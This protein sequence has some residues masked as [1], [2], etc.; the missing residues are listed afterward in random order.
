MQQPP[1]PNLNQA[2]I[3]G[4]YQQPS[5]DGLQRPLNP[6]TNGIPPTSY[7]RPTMPQQQYQQAAPF[8]PGTRPGFNPQ[9]PGFV[10]PATVGGARPLPQQPMQPM[11]PR[12]MPAMSGGISPNLVG[13]GTQQPMSQQH[14]MAGMPQLQMPLQ[15]QP[16]QQPMQQ[17][18]QMQQPIQQQPQQPVQQPIQQQPMQ[19]NQ[20]M[21]TAN[22]PSSRRA[23]PEQMA[24]YGGPAS[25]AIDPFN[26][27]NVPIS[28]AGY[29][30]VDQGMSNNGP[31]YNRNPSMAQAP[32]A[33]GYQPQPA[34]GMQ[35][36]QQYGH[37]APIQ[38][39]QQQQQQPQQGYGSDMGS[40]INSFGNMAVGGGSGYNAAS[41]QNRGPPGVNLLQGIP[42]ATELLRP[43]PPFMMA[44]TASVS[45]APTSNS[46]PS[47]KRC[48]VG[49]VPQTLQL[50]NKSKMPFALVLSPYRNIHPGEEPVPVINPETIVRCR[51]CRSYI[52]PWI[53]FVDQGTRW[54]C[55]LCFLTNEVPQF[56]DYDMETR[57]PVDRLKRT[58][59]THA[60]VE[61]VAP[62]E[63]M[64]RPPQPVV[65][66]FL[67]D[68][69]YAAIQSGMVATAVRTILESLDSIPNTDDRTKI[70]FITVDSTIHFYNL[71]ATLTEPQMLVVSDLEDVFL[72]QPED[73]LVNLSE[74]RQTIE[75]LLK[76]IPDMFAST[77]NVQSALGPALQAAYKLVNPIGGKIVCLQASLPTL[78]AGALKVRED[79]KLFGT[80]KE[81]TLL[82]PAIPFYKTLAVDCSRAQVSIDLFLFSGQYMDLATL[83]GCA[84]Y[85]GGSVYYYPGFNAARSEDAL[86]FAQELSHFMGRPIG[87]EA[88]LRVRASKGIK[89]TAFHG[90]FFL[91]STDLLAL[92]N[93]NPD[94]AY[95]VEMTI[96]ETL[97][98][99]LCCF[100]TAVLHTSSNGERRIRV[101]TLALP[102]TTNLADMFST[103]DQY[104]LASIL[105]KKG[106]DRVL[107]SRLEDA[108]EA[109]LNKLVDIISVFKSNFTTSGQ[110]VQLLLP[111]NLK[112]L[113]ML[114][115]GIIKNLA[116]RQGTNIPSDMRYFMLGMLYTISTDLNTVMLAARFF[117]IHAMSAERGTVGPDGK[118]I[119][120][121]LIN[122]SSE[123]LDRSGLFMLEN[124]LEIFIWVGRAVPPELC[125]AIFDKPSYDALAPGKF[126][127]PLLQNN[128]SIRVNNIVNT[129]RQARLIDNTC[130]PSISIVKED[131]TDP[132]LR[133]YFLSHLIEDRMDGHPS[134]PQYLSTLHEA[135][136]KVAS[137]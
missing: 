80:P 16:M 79:I 28:P 67:I 127:L 102:V 63:Y 66:L 18:Q 75:T 132:A 94:H 19:P 36:P 97:N 38:Q 83:S 6:P 130:Y 95:G 111:E 39:Q 14:P 113:P 50:L 99:G 61:Y 44:S 70:G 73:L 103:A 32:I 47:Y 108:R 57:Q 60:V 101:L 87:L 15:Q 59:L 90:N 51:R 131:G 4:V 109:I 58:E 31:A 1:N 96:E 27:Q 129:L 65:M 45:A 8:Q 116:F 30:P 85:T 25:Q 17:P 24:A 5:I 126:T 81:S 9:Q 53:Q 122:L 82:Q 137:A 128:M 35:Q 64:V 55:N 105:A 125:Q 133:A 106:V 11:Q 68:V 56:F 77:Q 52:N 74:C 89:M 92:P 120:P 26:P 72:P 54:K 69:T 10:N 46:D 93:V 110:A 33:A 118:T 124:G 7:G 117:A 107:S 22:R 62:Q 71:N 86:K 123:R 12:P 135:V 13:Q 121:N 88:V 119:M 78:H 37:A 134:Y 34:Y 84:K 114:I 91:R 29:A 43:P 98:T 136:S 3:N 23:Y 104:A 40:I 49:A 2:A 76:R 100:Q 21:S 41:G 115:M 20:P 42:L 112:L 48:T